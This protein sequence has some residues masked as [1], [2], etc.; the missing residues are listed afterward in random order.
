M[1]KPAPGDPKVADET[2]AAEALLKAFRAG[3]A[4]AIGRVHRHLPQVK[5]GARADAEAYRLT[6]QEAQTV[7]AREHGLQS[8]GEL[9]LRIKLREAGYGDALNQFI[10]LVYAHDAEKL[11]ELADRS[12][13]FAQYLGR[14]AF[15][16]WLDRA[17]HL[18]RAY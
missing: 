11:N 6:L 7:I 8:W 10:Q 9:R 15:L 12:S 2:R 5:Y 18:E 3:G 16:V 17:H 4:D 1:A 14:S 13:R